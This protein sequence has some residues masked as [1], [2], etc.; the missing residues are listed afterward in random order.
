[1]PPGAPPVRLGHLIDGGMAP[2]IMAIVDRG[3]QRRPGLARGLRAEVEL[4]ISDGPPPVRIV[5]AEDGVLV[6]DGA[7]S[8]PDLR[9][10]GT[11]P[12]LVALMVAPLLGGLP[13]PVAR[14]GRAALGMVAIG[15]VR[16]QGRIGL[17]RRLLGVVAI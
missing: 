3:L 1:M 9:V 5:F 15:R 17:L 11:L 12:D 6:E 16:V 2:A 7:C 8:A 13:N 10:I 4:C 14:R